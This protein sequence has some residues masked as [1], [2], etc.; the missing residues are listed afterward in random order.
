M[1]LI[2]LRTEIETALVDELGQYVLSN[3]TS[4]PAISVRAE[5]EDLP[6][7]TSVEGVECVIMRYPRQQI[8]RQ[9]ANVRAFDI[10]TVYLVDW[11]SENGLQESVHLLS[12][13]YPQ[14]VLN[15]VSTQ[16]DAGPNHQVRMEFRFNPE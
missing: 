12:D 10:Y 14:L 3:G 8:I 1:N 7:G 16:R 15:S 2:N 6:P 9:Y 11:D 13:L 4:T 5:G